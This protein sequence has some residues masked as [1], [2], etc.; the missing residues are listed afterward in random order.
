M[1]YMFAFGR[2]KIF[3]EIHNTGPRW[4]FNGTKY[5]KQTQENNSLP[6]HFR[7]TSGSLPVNRFPVRISSSG[8]IYFIEWCWS[9]HHIQIYLFYLFQNR[10]RDAQ[11]QRNRE[12]Q[13]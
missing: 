9:G 4:I 13:F 10:D 11:Q 7:S 2:G 3:T 12:L 8:V 1:E 5:C 6:A